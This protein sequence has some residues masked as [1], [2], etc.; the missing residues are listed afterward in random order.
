MIPTQKGQIVRFHTPFPDE[1]SDQMYVVIESFYDVEKPRAL[2]KA[3]GFG[4]TLAPTSTVLIEDLELVQLISEDLIGQ[5]MSVKTAE[6][7]VIHGKV[8][9]VE[10]PDFGLNIEIEQ[11]SI[12]TNAKV[13]IQHENNEQSTGSLIVDIPSFQLNTTT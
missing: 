8:L 2:I 4:P 1:D 12:L 13:T 9:K 5:E 11:N 7:K 3:L 6:G 10:Y